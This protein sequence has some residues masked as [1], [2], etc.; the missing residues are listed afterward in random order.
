M[1]GKKFTVYGNFVKIRAFLRKNAPLNKPCLNNTLLFDKFPPSTNPQSAH[2]TLGAIGEIMKTFP[3]AHTI[4]D[5]TNISYGLPARKLFNR[6]FRAA[7]ITM[8]LDSA[9]ID[10]T[11]K[12]PYAMLKT[13]TFVVV[14]YNFCMD[15]IR[16]FREG[17]FE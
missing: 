3:G 1:R 7:A 11:D 10:P 12:L 17:R 15:Y 13:V 14:K 5:L 8:G 2:V 4:C 9:I 16:A 6:A